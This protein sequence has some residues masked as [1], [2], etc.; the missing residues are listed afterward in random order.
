[1]AP[2]SRRHWKQPSER[3][4]AH[5]MLPLLSQ[6]WARLRRLLGVGPPQAAPAPQ[7]ASPS[8]P[9]APDADDWWT[10]GRHGLAKLFLGAGPGLLGLRVQT[11]SGEV[12][13]GGFEGV[14]ILMLYEFCYFHLLNF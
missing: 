4:P 13:M 9:E 1:M 6:A 5:S 12:V 10:S 11:S 3:P 7:A 14:M 8:S 2:E